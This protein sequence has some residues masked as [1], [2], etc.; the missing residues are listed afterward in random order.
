MFSNS[1]SAELQDFLSYVSTLSFESAPD[2]DRCRNFFRNGMKKR[3]I[4]LDGKLD[5]AAPKTPAKKVR[6]K[7]GA[8][9]GTAKPRLA[10]PLAQLAARGGP[11][12]VRK[13]AAPESNSDEDMEQ[14]KRVYKDAGSQTSPGFVKRAREAA[15]RTK[16][17]YNDANPEMESFSKKA[18]AAAR[19]ASTNGQRKGST[20]TKGDAHENNHSSLSNPTAAMLVLM[21]RKAARETA[22]KKGKKTT[23]K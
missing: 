19:A 8:R 7:R 17:N 3:K 15:K 12:A 9:L 11:L 5:F 6:T 23:K 4:A 2:Y 20:T 1:I 13:R 21:E 16:R 22:S 18:I 14:E 10:Q